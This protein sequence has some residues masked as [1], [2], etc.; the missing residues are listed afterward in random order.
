MVDVELPTDPVE[1]SGLLSIGFLLLALLL[2]LLKRRARTFHRYFAHLAWITAVVHVGL[3]LYPEPLV[4]RALTAA[5]I[6]GLTAMGGLLMSGATA[7]GRGK[8]RAH[9]AT[10]AS[11]ARYARSWRARHPYAYRLLHW[12]P[13]IIAVVAIVAHVII[14]QDT[15][16]H[17]FLWLII[18]EGVAIMMIGRYV[19][20]GRRRRLGN[21]PPR[22]AAPIAQQHETATIQRTAVVPTRPDKRVVR[23]EKIGITTPAQVP[24]CLTYSPDRVLVALRDKGDLLSHRRALALAGGRAR[25]LRSLDDLVR[26]LPTG[27]DRQIAEYVVCGDPVFLTTVH[28]FLTHSGVPYTRIHTETTGSPVLPA[29]HP[30]ARISRVQDTDRHVAIRAT[31]T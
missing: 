3:V 17:R 19:I 12:S 26:E 4:L 11:R 20:P 1:I 28:E 10:T 2:L 22:H 13:G 15:T 16:F 27:E 21:P 30:S 25:F 8:R 31:R 7:A 14:V 23:Y 6:S 29:D 5:E 24:E 18:A 9:A